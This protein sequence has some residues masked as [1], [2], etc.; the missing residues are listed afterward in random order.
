MNISIDKIQNGWI[1][2]VSTR[3]GRFATHFR[4]WSDVLAYLAKPENIGKNPSDMV[5]QALT[6]TSNS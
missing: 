1:V 2:A 5:S 3:E 4:A 6:Q